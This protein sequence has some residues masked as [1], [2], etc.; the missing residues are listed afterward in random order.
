MRITTKYPLKKWVTQK[1]LS[2]LCWYSTPKVMTLYV[3]SFFFI[4]GSCVCRTWLFA[5]F[6]HSKSTKSKKEEETWLFWFI[7]IIIFGTF[8]KIYRKME[9]HFVLLCQRVEK[10][11]VFQM[12]IGKNHRQ[13]I[14][15]DNSVIYRWFGGRQ[16]K[17]VT[18]N[19]DF[20]LFFK[21]ERK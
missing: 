2:A 16:H 10:T 18:N 11:T 15:C 9:K 13:K 19:K 1:I 8:K 3:L 7:I 20:F 21:N 12:Y 5:C 14:G 17:K 4:L 6:H